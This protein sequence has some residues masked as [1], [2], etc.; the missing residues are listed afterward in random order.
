MKDLVGEQLVELDPAAQAVTHKPFRVDRSDLP[1]QTAPHL[2]GNLVKITFET[3][4]SGNAAAVESSFDFF[5]GDP[6]YQAQQ[7]CIGFPY[8]LL[9]KMTGGIVSGARG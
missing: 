9:P 2:N 7:T 4:D 6:R 5:H 8:V 3:H 1:H